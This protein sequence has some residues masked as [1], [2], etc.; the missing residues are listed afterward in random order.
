MSLKFAAIV[1][2]PPMMLPSIGK[3]EDR[4]EI[5]KTIE[6]ME[7]LG[8]EVQEKRIDKIIVASPHTDWGFD[9]PLY[10]LTK[11]FKGAIETIL[12][13]ETLPEKSFENGRLFYE[14]EIKNS[15]LNIA[16]VASGDLSHRLKEDGPYGLHEDGIKFDKETLLALEKK[17]NSKLLKLNEMYPEAGE[18]GLNSIS[19]LMGALEQRREKSNKNYEPKALSY[20]NSF[21]VGYLVL[22][23][24]L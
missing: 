3:E 24:L 22:K 13:E 7:F 5:Q 21:G 12:I 20:E 8:E 14:N 17:D 4:L 10:F 11:N 16:L 2:H 15:P 1:P 19:F 6:S 9:V 23:Y 18:C